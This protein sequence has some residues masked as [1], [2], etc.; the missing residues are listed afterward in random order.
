MGMI[1]DLNSQL[2]ISVWHRDDERYEY[3]MCNCAINIQK[4]H[5]MKLIK[6]YNGFMLFHQIV[7]T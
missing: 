1:D 6:Q 2:F 5:I 7:T 4:Y 3:T